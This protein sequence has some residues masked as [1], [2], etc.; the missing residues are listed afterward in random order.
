MADPVLPTANELSLART[1]RGEVGRGLQW[2]GARYFDRVR[3]SPGDEA[4]L[5][6]LSAE[7]FVV[8]VMRTNAWINYLY[9]AWALVRRSL[10]PVRAVVNLTR[11]FGKPWRKAVMRGPLDVRF[12]YARRNGGSGLV[13]LKETALANPR[14]KASKEDPF[15]ALVELARKSDRPVYLVPELFVWE[16]R[17]Q[18][19][20]PSAFDFVWGSPEAPGLLHSFFAFWR[21]H[22]SAQFRVGEPVNLTEV[23]ASLA[24][25]DTARIARKVRG[26]LHH[27]LAAQTR[28]VF[29]P[30]A[31]SPDRIIEEVLRDRTLRVVVEEVAQET[32]RAVPKVTRYAEKAVRSIAARPNATALGI[33]AH[34][35][36]LIF[37][38]IYS[39]LDVDEEGLERAMMAGAR[40]PLV[41]TPSHKSHIDY[42][43]LSTIL[44]HRGYN[45]PLIAAGANLSFF[46]LG[47]YLRRISAFFM[48]RSF[49]GDRVYASAFKAYI[50]RLVHDG[51]LQEFFL[52]GGRSRTGK[53]LPPKLGM[54]TWQVEAVLDGARDDLNFVPIA[55]DN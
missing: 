30:P 8:H 39:G 29:G 38:R 20:A 46:P 2:V 42:L 19:I 41:L 40:A 32:G 47:P 54:L 53:L 22:A 6:R 27:H 51:I 12:T 31:K 24:G 13:F 28:A 45:T 14:A 25:E 49:K 15:P 11:F 1:L 33:T 4:L 37:N 17:Q 26:A 36:K 10:P 5:R 43:V 18:R 52:E 9:L 3:F 44:W 35:L 55:I 16:R 50:R 34:V 7:G 48:R 23:V 21:H